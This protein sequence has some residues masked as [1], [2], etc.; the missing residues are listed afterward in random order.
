MKIIE[1][2]RK[3]RVLHKA[4][5]GCLRDTFT[6]NVTRGCEFMCVYCYAR[7]Y[8]NAPVPGEVFLYRNLP[9]KLGAELESPRTRS[10]V[11]WV[12]FNTAS[13][14]FQTHPAV[15]DVALEAM[16]MLLE[17]SIGFSYLTKGRVP[18][19]FIRLFSRYPQLVHSTICLVSTRSRYQEIFEPHAAAPSE[20]LRNV[21]RLKAAGL[22]VDVRVDPII[23][24][25]T[26]DPDSITD[27]CS[28]LASRGVRR[29]S[30][31]YLHLR[32][33]VLDQLRNELSRTE[34]EL[35]R[36]CFGNRPMKEGGPFTQSRLTAP[37]VR[38]RGY[39]RFHAAAKD[40]GIVPLICAC[41]NPDMKGHLCTGRTGKRKKEEVGE[42]GRKQ[43]GLFQ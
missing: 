20:R 16:R 31:S 27:L 41:K 22:E 15:Q 24:F 6:L 35:L 1:I 5:F 8:P 4:Q 36:G 9:E 13:D 39:D 23:P 34:F 37:A 38:K 42:Q 25:I 21:E 10:R 7:G 3:S 29:I 33:A 32:P 19:R 14:C 43:L 11:H 12:A 40:A 18:D 2:E 30:L 26:D 17:R 28:A